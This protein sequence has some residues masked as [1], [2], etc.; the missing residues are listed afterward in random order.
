MFPGADG[1]V[2]FTAR[3]PAG[4]LSFDPSDPE[5]SL[6]RCET[7]SLQE[8]DGVCLGPDGA[9]WIADTAANTIVRFDP[10]DGSWTTAG[11]APQVDGPFDI[12]PGPDGASVWFTNKT[13]NTI[14]RLSTVDE[15]RAGRDSVVDEDRG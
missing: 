14:G 8:P 2:W 10:A 13:G 12:K 9:L 4:L 3:A 5:G 11:T 15:A 7:A 1:R 6:E